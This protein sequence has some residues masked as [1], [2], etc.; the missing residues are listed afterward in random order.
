MSSEF[1][2]EIYETSNM[3]LATAE[4]I[5]AIMVQFLERN[6]PPDDF[7]RVNR[8]LQVGGG[9]VAPSTGYPGYGERPPASADPNRGEG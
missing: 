3:D 9:M 5:S 2:R 8:Y 1:V 6:L 4:K 7:A